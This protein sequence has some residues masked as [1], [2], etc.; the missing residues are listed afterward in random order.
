MEGTLTIQELNDLLDDLSKS[1][2]R[3]SVSLFQVLIS[4]ADE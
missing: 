3:L 1:D 2:K 4:S